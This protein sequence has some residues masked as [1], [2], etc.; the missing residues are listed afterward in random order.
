M[1]EVLVTK[2]YFPPTWEGVEEARRRH[3]Y[4]EYTELGTL[5]STATLGQLG[6]IAGEGSPI[7]PIVAQLDEVA[8]V[9]AD[10]LVT[11]TPE[12][13]E[14]PEE[15]REEWIGARL[16]VRAESVEGDDE[17]FWVLAR[18]ACEVLKR[19][20]PLAHDWWSSFYEEKGKRYHLEEEAR[21][22]VRENGRYG[23]VRD[24]KR[25]SYEVIIKS[26]DDEE[27]EGLTQAQYAEECAKSYIEE[28][29]RGYSYA[30]AVGFPAY[31][32]N[33]HYLGFRP[34]DGELLMKKS[35]LRPPRFIGDR[36]LV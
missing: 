24:P 30:G 34:T 25:P 23:F 4:D 14:A 1:T 6:R 32:M 16:P 13:G 18:E 5:A 28:H 35:F 26:D 7:E 31:F 17:Y 27:G 20:S 10:F 19:I 33:F 22:Y 9:Y 36:A 2:P 15:I 29:T 8:P 3:S 11:K 12:Q 21:K